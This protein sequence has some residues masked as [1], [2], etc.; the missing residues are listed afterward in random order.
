MR[1][2]LLLAVLAACGSP[3][4]SAD[5]QQPPQDSG[6]ADAPDN[7]SCMTS[8]T[9]PRAA[10]PEVFV[11][12]TGLETKLGSFID[13]AK[14]SIDLQ[15]YLFNDKV[16]RDKLIA[17]QGRGVTVRVILDP[18]EAANPATK[19]ALLGGNVQTRYATKI[20]DFSHAKYMV[21]DG[22][23]AVIMSMNFNVGAM[24]SERNYGFSETDP[25]D[26]ADLEAIFAMDWAA[27][28][29]ETA[30]PADL[31]CTRLVVSPNNS[32]Q[33]VL[34]LINGS[35]TELMFEAQY[36]SDTT[37]RNAIGA[38]KARGV[39]VRVILED[40]SEQPDNADTQTF[41]ANVGI[42]VKYAVDFYCHAKLIIADHVAFVGSENYSLT[43][44][45]MN[46]EV[47]ALVF[48]PGPEGTIESQFEDD[49]SSTTPAN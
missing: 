2:A 38:A 41:L 32:K 29:N 47:G 46:R 35:K 5:D 40:P 28:G 44:L 37:V 26:V 9:T 39:D 13:Q 10:P 49:W 16:L 27:A 19:T 42:P 24:D 22:S 48:E 15:M 8:V 21:L 31:S 45:T 30:Q 20:Y 43:S 12:P 34:S 23:K 36:I 7:P 1:R 11:G 6:T 4:N 17:A 25:D 33:R 3:A 14:T 18:D